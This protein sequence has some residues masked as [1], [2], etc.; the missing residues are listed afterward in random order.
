M[1]NITIFVITQKVIKL[2]IWIDGSKEI[3]HIILILTI[4]SILRAVLL[5]EHRLPCQD[6]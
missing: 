6:F 5:T 1:A 3:M 2:K 4:G